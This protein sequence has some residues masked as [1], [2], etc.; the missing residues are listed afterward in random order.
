VVDQG[1]DELVAGPFE[2]FDADGDRHFGPEFERLVEGAA[3]ERLTRDPG[4]KPQV[5]LD[6]R[7]GAGL[8]AHR[9]L[10]DDKDRQTFGRAIDGCREPGWP[11][12][13]DRDIIE[14]GLRPVRRRP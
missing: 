4:R 6:A 8:P 2:P 10:V 9:T 5:I 11:S 3:S 7:R 13:D 1:E 12:A 14:R